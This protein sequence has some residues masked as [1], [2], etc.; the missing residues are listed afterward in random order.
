MMRSH[1]DLLV[2]GRDEHEE[3]R[4]VACHAV[5]D[6]ASR[7]T[8]SSLIYVYARVRVWEM[9][10]CGIGD[11]R[12]CAGGF[13]EVFIEIHE[14]C[15][16]E[17]RFNKNAKAPLKRYGEN[18]KAKANA[19]LDQQERDPRPALPDADPTSSL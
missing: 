10:L 19:R 14:E 6:V 5:Q 7:H 15:E 13:R 9:W 16:T 8:R 3:A 1:R 2:A 12:V 11:L 18:Q 17:A 4:N